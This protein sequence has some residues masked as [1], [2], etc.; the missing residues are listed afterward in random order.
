M[1]P[2]FVH[3]NIFL[4]INFQPYCSCI[5]MDDHGKAFLYF[6]KSAHQAG[7]ASKIL[8]LSNILVLTQFS[9]HGEKG[10]TNEVTPLLLLK[11]DT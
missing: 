10:E 6:E 4:R 2:I 1:L 11:M 9:R 5:L 7:I 3:S 8:V